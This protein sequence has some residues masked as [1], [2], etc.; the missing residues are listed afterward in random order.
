MRRADLLEKTLRLGKIKGRRRGADEDEIDSITD[1]MDMDVH[2]LREIVEDRE[3]WGPAVHG[4][5]KSWAWL[6]TE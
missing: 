1:S 4:V 5:A 6:S 2:K 3:A